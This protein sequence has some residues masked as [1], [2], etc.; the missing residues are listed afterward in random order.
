MI[1]RLHHVVLDC[2]DP[3][4]LAG[5]YSALLGLPVTFQSEDWI[6]VAQ[7]ETSSGLAFQRVPAHRPPRWPDP[8][9]PQEMHFDVMVDDQEEAGRQ[10]LELGAS[11]LGGNLIIEMIPSGKLDGE[12]PGSQAKLREALERARGAGPSST[13]AE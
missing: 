13:A 5:F 7:D 2:R 11:A 8:E 1:G 6:V 3:V 4:E 10:V 12:F 9:W